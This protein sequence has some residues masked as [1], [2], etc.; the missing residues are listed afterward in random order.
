MI[1]QKQTHK[2]GDLY[3]RQGDVHFIVRRIP[4]D[5]K[6][7]PLRPFAVGETTGHAHRIAPSYEDMVEMYEDTDGRI[8]VRIVGVDV[9]S[10]HE[11]HDKEGRVSILP[12]GWEGEV[13]IAREYDEEEGFR[14]ITD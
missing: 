8:Y 2:D 14:R 4:K 3:G 5:A 10:I 13:V 12:A 6:R 11:D 9:P 7:V 1:K